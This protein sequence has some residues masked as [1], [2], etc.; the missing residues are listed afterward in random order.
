MYLCIICVIQY[1]T[2]FFKTKLLRARLLSFIN[3]RPDCG[4]TSKLSLTTSLIHV[5]N[6]NEE[7]EAT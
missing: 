5:A 7:G 3:E 1:G 2:I 6:H 4:V